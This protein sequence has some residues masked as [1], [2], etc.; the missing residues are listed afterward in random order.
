MPDRLMV[1]V[2]LG[3]FALQRHL[4]A[5]AVRC[6][7]AIVTLDGP[8]QVTLDPYPGRQGRGIVADG[9]A[10][11]VDG[12]GAE[13]AARRLTDAGPAALRWDDLDVLSYTAATVWTWLALPL[14]L[15]R[16]EL[17]VVARDGGA[18]EVQVPDGWPGAGRH[19]LHI[20]GDGRVFRHEEGH[21][22]HHL[23][24]H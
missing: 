15:D 1:I 23:S 2:S 21:V 3:G 6:R 18:L 16:P 22:V 14:A 7:P 9:W 5:G 12:D 4:R 10:R 13:V 20:D 11:L 17:T 19:L 8:P 24:G